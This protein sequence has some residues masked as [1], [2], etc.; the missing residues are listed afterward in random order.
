MAE[1]TK[2]AVRPETRAQAFLA[3]RCVLLFQA[4]Q[5][6]LKRTS[7]AGHLYCPLPTEVIQPGLNVEAWGFKIHYLALIRKKKTNKEAKRR[8]SDLKICSL[9]Y[10]S[11]GEIESLPRILKTVGILILG[12]QYTEI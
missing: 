10:F 8:V 4:R 11:G 2:A 9:N 12:Q 6:L 3:A 5:S 7:P 1:A